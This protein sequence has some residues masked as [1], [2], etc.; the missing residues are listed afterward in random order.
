MNAYDTVVYVQIG[1]TT[2]IYYHIT[3]FQYSHL[4]WVYYHILS[5]EL[6]ACGV[7]HN[8][9]A[10]HMFSQINR[11]GWV[12]MTKAPTKRGWCKKITTYHDNWGSKVL[13]IGVDII[14]HIFITYNVYSFV[15]IYIIIYIIIYI[16]IYVHNVWKCW[17]V[18][19]SSAQ[20]EAVPGCAPKENSPV[21]P[22]LVKL[23]EL[24]K[25]CLL[26]N[27][28]SSRR[29]IDFSWSHYHPISS[30]VIQY[31]P[32]SPRAEACG[33]PEGNWIS[34]WST[35]KNNIFHCVLECF[36]FFL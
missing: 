27:Y 5:W 26:G 35:L 34:L 29:D 17:F 2:D 13:L 22:N 14:Y 33:S 36:V 19:E 8:T 3:V 16:Y 1:Y 23:K 4:L 24:Q 10:G 9:G 7:A 6:S 21:L 11:S 30:N 12:A 25:G 15:Y 32:I 31:H 20:P 18:C 28:L